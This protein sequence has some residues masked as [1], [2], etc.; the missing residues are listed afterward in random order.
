MDNTKRFLSSEERF[1]KSEHKN[2]AVKL[3]EQLKGK[4]HNEIEEIL[5]F[6]KM[7]IDSTFKLT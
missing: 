2:L 1:E 4:T 7:H 6:V 3:A 5:E